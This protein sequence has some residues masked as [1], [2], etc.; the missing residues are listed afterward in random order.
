[1]VSRG[2][3][4]LKNIRLYFCDFGGSSQGLRDTLQSQEFAD[5]VNH[6]EHLKIEIFMRRGQHP[7]MSSTYINGYTKDTPLRN[8][9]QDQAFGHLQQVNTEFGRRALQHNQ[10]KVLGQSRSI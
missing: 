6:N 1:M 5:W 3:H 10:Q 4:Q 8:S 2:V 7:Y 9:T